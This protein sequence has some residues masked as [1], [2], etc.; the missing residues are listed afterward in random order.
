MNQKLI[1]RPDKNEFLLYSMLD[2]YGLARGSPDSHFLRRKTRDHFSGY[3]GIGLA[4]KMYGHYSKPA[5][6]ALIL[7]EAPDFTERQDFEFELCSK[8]DIMSGRAVLPFLIHFYKNTDFEE[9]YNTILPRYK[10]D[11][12][13]MQRFL[14]RLK[15]NYLLDEIWKVDEPFND[16]VIPMPL[17]GSRSGVGPGFC[18]TAFH[19]IGP[20]F[21][22]SNL[23]LILHEGS[24]P[25]AKQGL[26]PIMSEIKKK[27]HL[28]EITMKNPDYSR[29][30]C[31]WRTCFE[32][33]LI[34]AMTICHLYPRIGFSDNQE[35]F[36]KTEEE[37][38]GMI[39][40]RD[41][42]D[43]I[44]KHDSDRMNLQEVALSI[45]KALDKKYNPD[46]TRSI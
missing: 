29:A 40:I 28:L 7:N 18:S 17:E 37:W 35:K 25:R 16:V 5:K 19:I 14:D 2:A 33:H 42:Y 20:P 39:F 13:F 31:T 44:R 41:F 45:L 27:S 9:F 36:L 38:N 26:K 8:R 24:H 4:E 23:D 30:Y 10:E 12:D 32:E 1:V 22:I 34:R 3:N 46:K 6:Y 43:E 15:I 11:C 21:D